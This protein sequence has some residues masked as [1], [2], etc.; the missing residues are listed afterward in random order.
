MPSQ[1]Y[2]VALTGGIGSGKTT[3]AERFASR[4]VAIVDTDACAHALT[5]AG[6]RALPAIDRAFGSGILGADGALDRANMRARVFA[7]PAAR[8]ALEEILHP[9]IR[10]EVES[11]L[12][13]ADPAA[14]YLML[15]VP[16]LFESMGYRGRVQR[17]LGVDCAIGLQRE[18]VR[19]RPGLDAAEVD[20]II[21]SQIAR[22]LRLQLVDDVIFNG[23]DVSRLEVQA[24]RLHERYLGLAA[25]FGRGEA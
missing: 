13:G 3:V 15:A 2:V 7:D 4:G 18:R 24:V 25:A 23:G 14:P 5:R 8:I 9:M 10:E 20:R 22:P 12:A 1:R 17:V 21:A 6:G 19:K 16:L 11:A